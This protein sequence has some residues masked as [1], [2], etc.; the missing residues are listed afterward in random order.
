MID[1]GYPHFVAR[2]EQMG[3]TVASLQPAAP[4]ELYAYWRNLGRLTGRLAAAEQLIARFETAVNAFRALTREMQPKKRVYFEAIHRRMKTFTPRSTA[5]FVL[6]TAGGINAAPD[7]EAVRS[8][9]I[10]AYG[11][12]RILDRGREIDVYLA[13]VGTMNKVTRQAILDEP[14]FQTIEAVQTGE[15][16]LIDETLVSRPTLRLLLGIYQIGLILYPEIYT[17]K[18]P[19]VLAAAG[20]VVP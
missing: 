8:T 9:N 20:L 3:I 6:E 14:G 17:E 2:L 12:E 11:K 1:G 18:G 4:A 10:A 19:P 16:H 5:I 15:V 13:Q 7:A